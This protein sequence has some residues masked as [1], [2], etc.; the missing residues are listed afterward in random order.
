MLARPLPQ[1]IIVDN[2]PAAYWFHPENAI[3]CSSYI[4]D[5]KDDELLIIENCLKS[6]ADK[7]DVREFLAQWRAIG[8]STQPAIT[9]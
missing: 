5:C 7:A 1:T 4:D 2:S 3:G 9:F 8:E 6:I